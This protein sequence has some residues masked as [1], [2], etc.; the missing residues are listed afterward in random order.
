[1]KSYKNES[2]YMIIRLTDNESNSKCH[3][4]HRLVALTFIHNND[5][6]NKKF[7]D[8]INNIRDD[9]Q[10]TNLRWVTRKENMN[11]IHDLSK[12][13]VKI[14]VIK[15]NESFQFR[16]IQD[17]LKSMKIPIYIFNKN[18]DNNE[19][20]YKNCE[21]YRKKNEKVKIINK[22]NDQ[23]FDIGYFENNNFSNYKISKSGNVYKNNY[24]LKTR[25]CSGYN[26]VS[27][28]DTESN[29]NKVIKIHR[30][31]GH[32]FIK[33]PDNYDDSLVINHI[34]ENKLNNFLENLEWCS[35]KD[36]TRKYFQQKICQIDI[37]TNKIIKMYSHF[38]DYYK[39]TNK[40]Y[41]SG[42]SKCCKGKF[43][44]AHG[45]KWKI[46]E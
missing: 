28:F 17:A 10:V 43:K 4:V 19:F 20:K 33:K 1:M 41:G 31:L 6:S 39:E 25:I 46:I 35:P 30:I 13:F 3:K 34:D 9:N 2:G 16:N 7:V 37:K 18:K 27:L 21:I 36:N 42:I 44:T 14:T 22:Q 32:C 26:V 15:N 23:V 11:N 5:P 24:L 12:N 40:K 38:S 29:K 45:F 8:H